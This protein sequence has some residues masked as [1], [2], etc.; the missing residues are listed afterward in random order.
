[1]VERGAG[2]RWGGG[3]GCLKVSAASINVVQKQDKRARENLGN[4]A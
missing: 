1:M 4:E 2:S 3:E